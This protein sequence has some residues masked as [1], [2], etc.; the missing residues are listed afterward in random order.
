MRYQWTKRGE[1]ELPTVMMIKNTIAETC[2][3]FLHDQR[4]TN[5]NCLVVDALVAVVLFFYSKCDI[6]VPLIPQILPNWVI[7]D[8]KKHAVEKAFSR[9]NAI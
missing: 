5:T 9:T 7:S 8:T 6:L 2:S 1:T 4:L 3:N